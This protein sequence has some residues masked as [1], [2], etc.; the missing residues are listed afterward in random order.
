METVAESALPHPALISRRGEGP[1]RALLINLPPIM[2]EQ[3]G[4]G[5]ANQPGKGSKFTINVL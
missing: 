5:M 4:P 3:K 1:P 2:I